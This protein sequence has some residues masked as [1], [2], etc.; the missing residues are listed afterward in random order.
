[1]DVHLFDSKD[2]PFKRIEDSLQD[3]MRQEE[4]EDMIDH[5]EYGKIKVSKCKL[6]P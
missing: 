1:L 3:I 4:V 6:L 5:D 2:H